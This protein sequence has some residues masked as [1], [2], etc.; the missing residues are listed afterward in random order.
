M[1][2]S[3]MQHSRRTCFQRDTVL[4]RRNRTKLGINMKY[5]SFSL[6]A[7]AVASRVGQVVRRRLALTG[8]R[9]MTEILQVVP[10]QK[11]RIMKTCLL[12]KRLL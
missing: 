5:Q 1:A 10:V 12:Y 8:G 11:V 4:P 7:V 2:F 9:M 6:I 3:H